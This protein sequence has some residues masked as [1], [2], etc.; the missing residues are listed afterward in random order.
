MEIS[1]DI[2][3]LGINYQKMMEI[4]LQN[5]D[6]GDDNSLSIEET[7]TPKEGLAKIDEDG[8]GPGGMDELKAFFPMAELDR[9]A[10]DI[11]SERDADGD[12][13]LSMDE[14]KMSEELFK[15]ADQN[16]DGLLDKNELADLAA[17]ASSHGPEASKKGGGTG[18]TT[19]SVV[20][21]DTDGDGVV[22]TEE[23]TTYKASGEVESV[24]TSPIG[25]SGSGEVGLGE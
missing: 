16:G 8:A 1:G 20:Q 18:G 14:V 9:V 10:A 25:D 5:R 2:S 11:I 19:E 22:D 23:V 17:K 13:L 21:I 12:G 6:E 4:M 7:S 3:A 24:T 15:K